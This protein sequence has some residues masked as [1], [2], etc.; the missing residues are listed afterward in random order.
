MTPGS[1][2]VLLHAGDWERRWTAAALAVTAAAHGDAV[3]VALFGAALRDWVEGRFDQ[4]APAGAGA[5]RAG[6]PTAMLEEGRAELGLR[7]LACDTAVR[8]AG[9]DPE[10]A[11]SK[12]EI[13]G[14][15]ALWRE[16]RGGQIL[17]W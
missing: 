11:A 9:L 17:V 13:T 4:G 3:R 6:S 2:L 10:V 14:L 15:P 7:L 1:L 8:L 5:A 12:V 16:G